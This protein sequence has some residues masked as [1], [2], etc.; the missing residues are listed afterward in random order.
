MVS[1]SFSVS[2][3]WMKQKT[4]VDHLLPINNIKINQIQTMS[5]HKIEGRII[6]L[7]HNMSIDSVIKLN[8]LSADHSLRTL[9]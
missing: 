4:P 1:N 6:N 2:Y 9:V 3:N 7:S 8:Y 5:E